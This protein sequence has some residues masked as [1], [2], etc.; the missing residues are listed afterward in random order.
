MFLEKFTTGDIAN[1]NIM[2]SKL[3]IGVNLL[4]SLSETTM[5]IYYAFKGKWNIY[6]NLMNGRLQCY[7]Y[8]MKWHSENALN[9]FIVYSQHWEKFHYFIIRLSFL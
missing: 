6:E 5:K 1:E 8:A 2:K 9:F 3:F 4:M 7:E